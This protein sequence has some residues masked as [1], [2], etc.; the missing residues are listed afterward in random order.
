MCKTWA[1]KVVVPTSN[2]CP[3][4]Q[5]CVIKVEWLAQVE[6]FLCEQSGMFTDI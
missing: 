2:S 1:I 3:A 5:M 6:I 4:D